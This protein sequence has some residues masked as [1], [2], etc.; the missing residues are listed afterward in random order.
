MRPA[1]PLA[2]VRNREQGDRVLGRRQ[3]AAAQTR[4]LARRHALR[5]RRTGRCRPSP[6]ERCERPD[7]TDHQPDRPPDGSGARAVGD[8]HVHL[9]PHRRLRVHA[10]RRRDGRLWARAVRQPD[11]IRVRSPSAGTRSR[12]E[13]SS[14]TET[15]S[16]AS[17]SWTI[18]V[19]SAGGD[20]PGA[21]GS[22]SGDS[23]GGS[24][25]DGG[26]STE[27]PASFDI[28]GDVDGL[29]AGHHQAD[30]PHAP[31]PERRPDLRDGGRRRHRRRQHASGLCDRAEHRA[32]PVLRHQRS[33]PVLVP[34]HGTVVL[35]HHPEAPQISFLN[36]PWNQDV[37]KGKSFELTYSGSA[38]S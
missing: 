9:R 30:R 35:R 21:G 3:A 11:L 27:E 14:D 19:P 17:Y 13:P 4:R 29:A 37:C 1:P 23:D 15:S 38:H 12:C 25:G 8:V 33:S 7:G 36:R 18:V 28:A 24:S 34:G 6:R 5:P 10:R 2:C 32:R 22:G 31:Q 16:P 26:S 20:A